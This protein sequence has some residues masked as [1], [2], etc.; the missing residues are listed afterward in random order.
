MAAA[1]SG[2][3]RLEKKRLYL[4]QQGQK[5]SVPPLKEKLSLD[6]W[7]DGQL[8]SALS[9]QRPPHITQSWAGQ[10]DPG[11][12]WRVK[13]SEDPEHISS[14]EICSVSPKQSENAKRDRGPLYD[15][16]TLPL[17]WTRKLK[18]R[19]TG[20]SAGKYDVYL[21][22]SEGK[23]FRSKVEL[24]AYFQK[25]GDT[26]T[27]PNDFDFT[28]TGRGCPSR[29]EKRLVKKPKV[30]KPVGRRRG[31]PKGSGKRRHIDGVA[32]KRVVE[33]SPGKLLVKMPLNAL[34]AEVDGPA[35]L[36]KVPVAKK[37][38]GRKRKT[39]QDMHTAPKKRGRKPKGTTPSGKITS[40]SI[41]VTLPVTVHIADVRLK[42]VRGSSAKSLQETALPI[43][44]RKIMEDQTNSSGPV[45][46]ESKRSDQ[47]AVGT[48]VNMNVLTE[49][50]KVLHTDT[51]TEKPKSS[52]SM[53]GR[54]Y[55]AS[56]DTPSNK[57]SENHQTAQLHKHQYQH[58]SHNQRHC[59]STTIPPLS[60]HPAH[61][62][63]AV[64]TCEPQDLSRQR[65]YQPQLQPLANRQAV[66]RQAHTAHRLLSL[67]SGA[68]AAVATEPKTKHRSGGRVEEE[69][70]EMKNAV[71]ASAV[72]RPNQEET[73]ESRTSVT[74]RLC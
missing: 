74:E 27:D 64:T 40:P 47:L 29:R 61:A 18:Q 36:A 22:N 38:R 25:I 54:G 69:E 19:K 10:D 55:A 66:I 32:V 21:I 42:A 23:A 60:L 34:R 68:A 26:N 7:D 6:H 43:K 62:Q 39:E 2:G 17:G 8:K 71:V 16:P 57:L 1:D 41:N 50:Q 35:E 13:D 63:R 33:Q 44:K 48:E 49:E 20:R 31:R 5:I 45:F 56:A 4:D 73:V 70:E 58:S 53:A 14:Q 59:P 65:P 52:M 67:K 15:D 11:G 30:M 28:V 72:P 51:P 24:I 37:R 3:R 46:S 12:P 9:S